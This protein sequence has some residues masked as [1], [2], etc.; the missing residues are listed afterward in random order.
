[1]VDHLL[2]CEERDTARRDEVVYERGEILAGAG[3]GELLRRGRW[4]AP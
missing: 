4:R 3:S 2:L 1:M